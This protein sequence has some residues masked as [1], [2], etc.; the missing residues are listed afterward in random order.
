MSSKS[1]IDAIFEIQEVLSRIE[2]KIGLL[3][4]SMNNLNNKMYVINSKIKNSG[5]DFG[6]NTRN[7]AQN[8]E[9]MPSATAPG[10]SA[11]QSSKLVLG[12]I[13][14][15]GY[16]LNKAKNPIPNVYV[17]V[18]TDNNEVIRDVSTGNDGMWECRLPSGQ[19]SVEYTHKN[20]KPINV[21]VTIPAGV[22]SFEVK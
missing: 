14:V 22:K 21:S 8:H 18:F 11:E 7:S 15:Y 2:S 13:K 6:Q 5:T 10:T 9:R 12:N 4:T 3:E 20:F 17:R 19:Y 1:A 16:I